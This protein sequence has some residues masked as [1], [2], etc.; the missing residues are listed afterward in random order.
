MTI[1]TD[2]D[3]LRLLIGDTDSAAVLAQDDELDYFLGSYPGNV[4]KAAAAVCDMLAVKFARYYDFQTDG[5]TFNRSQMSKQYAA[6]AKELKNRA[7]G[8][9]AL[10]TVRKDGYSTTVKTSDVRTGDVNQRQEFY[11]VDG[12]DELP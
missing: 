1:S 10:G 3:K 8:L 11:T 5:Q 2:R 6:L 7:T 4:L 12:V 9:A